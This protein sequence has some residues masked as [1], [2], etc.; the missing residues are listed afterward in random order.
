M[1]KKKEEIPLVFRYDY[2]KYYW[3]GKGWLKGKVFKKYTNGQYQFNFEAGYL[4]DYVPDEKF[5]PPLLR[6]GDKTRKGNKGDWYLRSITRKRKIY[7]DCHNTSDPYTL[8]DFSAI[9]PNNIFKL[10]IGGKVYCYNVVE[11]YKWITSGRTAR[12]P[13]TNK[14]FNESNISA[15][16]SFYEKRAVK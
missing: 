6:K 7:D 14:D 1:A 5:N 8:D 3:P 4:I 11:L 9:D 16:K 13:Y 10:E 15:I 2:I 12:E